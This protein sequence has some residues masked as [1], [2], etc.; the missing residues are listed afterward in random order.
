MVTLLYFSTNAMGDQQLP[1]DGSSSTGESSTRFYTSHEA[2]P[3][4]QKSGDVNR[5]T[6]DRFQGPTGKAGGLHPDLDTEQ[7]QE[8]DSG[9]EYNSSKLGSPLQP[10]TRPPRASDMSSYQGP[11]NQSQDIRFRA[12]DS[13]QGFSRL[14]PPPP[15]KSLSSFDQDSNPN[16]SQSQFSQVGQ[17]GSHDYD[18]GMARYGS[19][20][21]SGSGQAYTP[22]V[23]QPGSGRHN[24]PHQIAA[25]SRRF[26]QSSVSSPAGIAQ[27]RTRSESQPGA[28]EDHPINLVT[29]GMVNLKM[30]NEVLD[31]LDNHIKSQPNSAEDMKVV[32]LLTMRPEQRKEN[33]LNE[34]VIDKDEENN[35]S[36][37][38]LKEKFESDHSKD[39][40]PA[41]RDPQSGKTYEAQKYADNEKSGQQN[42]ENSKQSSARIT[43]AQSDVDDDPLRAKQALMDSA[44]TKLESRSEQNQEQ[45]RRETRSVTQ[46]KKKEAA[47]TESANKEPRFK[48][49]KHKTNANDVEVV[50]EVLL[51]PEMAKRG[52]EVVIVFGSPLSDWNTQMVK[53]EPITN[54]IKPGNYTYLTGTL[55]L[56]ADFIARSIPY[57]YVVLE[58][59]NKFAWEFIYS[60]AHHAK[61]DLNRCLEV[62]CSTKSRFFKFDDVILPKEVT[63]QSTIQKSGRE[64]A[65]KWMLPRPGS[66]KSPSFDLEEAFERFS[67]VVKAH[68]SNGTKV[69]VGDT[70]KGYYNP[71]GYSIEKVVNSQLD[72]LFQVFEKLVQEKEKNLEHLFRMALYICLMTNTPYFKINDNYKLLVIFDVFWHCRDFLPDRL[73]ISIHGEIQNEIVEALKKLVRSF[74]DLPINAWKSFSKSGD[75]LF[76]MPFIHLWDHSTDTSNTWLKLDQWKESLKTRYE[77]R[78]VSFRTRQ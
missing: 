22:A 54:L 72:D 42:G 31:E 26:S 62:P 56:A 55:P 78:Q 52:S 18:Q 59:Y 7:R 75:W 9:H 63:Y 27:P 29:S 23:S 10:P 37:K 48:D 45:F 3:Q 36:V 2:T 1:T 43:R 28:N 35:R 15:P 58:G 61:A 71:N 14:R 8:V 13:R 64:M 73:P 44:E 68:R 5:H 76:V 6:S 4:G 49:Y 19:P 12:N 34:T 40:Q 53:M 21:A 51:S 32:A 77:H 11:D 33:G 17:Q 30:M 20:G 57:K 69:C 41:T 38:E 25:G 39:G 24:D 70:P 16:L 66:M 50:F 65:T 74:V 47:A 60:S 67:L 46:Q